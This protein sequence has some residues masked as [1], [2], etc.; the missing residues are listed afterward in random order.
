ML[1]PP[2]VLVESCEK[3]VLLSG[4]LARATGKS[5]TMVLVSSNSRGKRSDEQLEDVIKFP[6]EER[7]IHTDSLVLSPR[8]W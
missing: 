3:S 5:G 8:L 1:L 7:L 6:A 4:H 2:P